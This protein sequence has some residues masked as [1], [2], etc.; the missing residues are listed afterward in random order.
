MSAERPVPGTPLIFRWRKWDGSPHWR[1]E[2]VYLGADG[3]GDW[4][5]QPIGWRSE[6]PGAAVEAESPNVTLI[7]ADA[8]DHA[9]TVNRGHPRD[10]RVYIDM[11]WDVRWETPLLATGI[12]M[13]LDVVRRTDE[14]GTY[15]D[16]R[17]EWAEHSALYGYPAEVMARLEARTLEI[18][19][20]VRAQHPPY[21]D[22]TADG[23]LDRLAALAPAGRAPVPDQRKVTGF[24]K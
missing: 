21:D 5:G 11:A 2:C 8:S 4:V 1:H 18:E 6:R 10:L 22:A 13:D 14:R 16:D 24:E 15:V 9:L 3:W 23:W 19:R 20:A 12:D 7:P 17:D